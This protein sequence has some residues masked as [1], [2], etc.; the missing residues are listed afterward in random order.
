MTG[1]R[2]PSIADFGIATLQRYARALGYRIEVKL[3]KQ[4]RTSGRSGALR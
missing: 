4:E 2:I 3:V 1:A